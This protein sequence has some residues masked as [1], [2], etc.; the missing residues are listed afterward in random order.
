MSADA[1]DRRSGT[2]LRLS[3][4]GQTIPRTPGI[5]ESVLFSSGGSFSYSSGHYPIIAFDSTH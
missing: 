2:E 5:A 4:D 3:F 1:R